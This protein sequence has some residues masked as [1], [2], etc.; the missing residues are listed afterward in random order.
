[1]WDAR[2]LEFEPGDLVLIYVPY[3]GKGRVAKLNRP[4]K[5]PY[6]II[7]RVNDLNYVIRN[8]NRAAD[9]QRVHVARMDQM[10]EI[11]DLQHPK[12]P[13]KLKRFWT[14]GIDEDVENTSF[15]S[16]GIRNGTTSGSGRRISTPRSCSSDSE[17]RTEPLACGGTLKQHPP[18]L[19]VE[20][21][22]LDSAQIPAPKMKK[23]KNTM[24]TTRDTYELSKKNHATVTRSGRTRQP[25][26]RLRDYELST[27][28]AR[29]APRRK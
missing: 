12:A 25:N 8:V 11:P 26:V 20:F 13:G 9:E 14:C 5:G 24:A 3:V 19:F 17:A 4:W 15:D 6:R 2:M 22:A 16:P 7:E 27:A 21:P 18:D 10:P 1:M 29:G 23:V 28:A